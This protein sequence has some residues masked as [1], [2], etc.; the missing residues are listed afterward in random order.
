MTKKKL[1]VKYKFDTALSDEEV[2]TR[3]TNAF[4]I[5][6]ANYE[7]YMKQKGI[8]NGKQKVQVAVH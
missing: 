7:I 4:Q 6:F 8:L 3:L 5:I 2:Q 1:R